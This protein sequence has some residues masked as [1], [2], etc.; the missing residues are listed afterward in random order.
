MLGAK[1]RLARGRHVLAGEDR[2][3]AVADQLQH[4]AAGLM[5]GVDRGFRIIVEERND[6]VGPDALGNPGRAA[7][8]GEPQHR[9]DA[10]G[11]AA[12]DAPA[13][14][15]GR[16]VAAEIDSP[17]RAGDVDLLRRLDRQ[18]QHRHEIAQC[19]QLPVAEAALAAGGEIG[20]EAVHLAERSGV[21]EAMDQRD[22]MP[23]PALEE[24]ADQ[25]ELERSLVGEIDPHLV[26]AIF[27]HVMEGR[28]APV[29]GG[30]ALCRRAIFEGVAFIARLVVPA[31]AAPFID[32][33]QRIDE[34]HRA[35]QMQAAVAAA[36][37]EAANQL[38]FGKTGETL[39]DQPV[40]QVETCGQFH[41][42]IMPRN[43][44]G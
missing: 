16:G 20:I 35:R 9:V 11:D 29:P 26:I 38:G 42:P 3:H 23:M 21:A 6:L 27:E 30:F 28:T 15:L 24:I 36:L 14:H 2:E 37:A 10:L 39:G 41:E 19:F 31:E 43:R 1:R 22:Q 4:V 32:R 18:S 5:N 13:Q 34:G 7:Q 40:H 25:R 12:R 33:V 8:I 17:Q 44:G